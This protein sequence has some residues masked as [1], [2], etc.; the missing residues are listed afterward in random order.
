MA[1]KNEIKRPPMP[2]KASVTAVGQ[3]ANSVLVDGPAALSFLGGPKSNG[4]RGR[5]LES[6]HDVLQRET[7]LSSPDPHENNNN[8][9]ERPGRILT[10]E[11]RELLEQVRNDD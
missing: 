9:S 4:G 3:R 8:L 6:A 11:E 5:Q 10:R 7:S 2:H 1:A